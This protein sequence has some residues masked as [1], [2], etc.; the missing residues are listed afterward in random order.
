MATLAEVRQLALLD[1]D[2][3]E[4]ADRGRRSF[5]IDGRLFATMPDDRTL[6]IV[7]GEAHVLPMAEA[8]PE[9]YQPLYLDDWLVGLKV[10]LNT[11]EAEQVAALLGTAR[12]HVLRTARRPDLNSS[13][14]TDG[15]CG[16]PQAA[17]TPTLEER[18]RAAR[19]SALA[20]FRW[21]AGRTQRSPCPRTDPSTT[22]RLESERS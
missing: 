18:R 20:T 10:A 21:A 8:R 14:A 11:A 9:T 13:P 17:Q 2:A 15:L 22:Q 19:A 1:P 4:T 16:R 5:R 3:D 7:L 12:T 6:H